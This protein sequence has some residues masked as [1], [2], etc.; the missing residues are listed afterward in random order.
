MFLGV[1][2]FVG[3]F[4]G[5]TRA[6]N[7]ALVERGGRHWESNL[8]LRDY[9]RAN[10]EAAREYAKIERDAL[11]SGVRSLLAYSGYKSAC[12]RRLI[13]RALDFRSAQ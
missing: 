11:K 7:V 12:L 8:A 13:S 3:G 1:S 5:G 2:I 6:F 9:L 10:P 4:A